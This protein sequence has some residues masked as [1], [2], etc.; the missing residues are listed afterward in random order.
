LDGK[1]NCDDALDSAQYSGRARR[2]DLL[3]TCGVIVPPMLWETTMFKKP[4]NFHP[5]NV[6]VVM[7]LKEK[8]AACK[9]Q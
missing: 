3:L 4:A 7:M 9:H 5:F 8:P 1:T 2:N 6:V